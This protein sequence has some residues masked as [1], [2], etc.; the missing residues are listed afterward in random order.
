MTCIYFQCKQTSQAID[1]FATCLPS[2]HDLIHVLVQIVKWKNTHACSLSFFLSIFFP[3]SLSYYQSHYPSLVLSLFLLYS[4]L[5]YQAHDTANICFTVTYCMCVLSVRDVSLSEGL[6]SPVSSAFSS[7]NAFSI[8]K[9]VF[10]HFVQQPILPAITVYT[11][12]L[13]SLLN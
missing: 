5:C 3:L 9:Q 13:F 11:G 8:S 12:D 4:L 6:T 7:K 2:T 1:G 10:V